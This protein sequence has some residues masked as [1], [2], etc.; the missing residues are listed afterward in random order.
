[1]HHFKSDLIENMDHMRIPG[2]EP[3]S[4]IIVQTMKVVFLKLNHDAQNVPKN[5]SQMGWCNKSTQLQFQTIL[6][7]ENFNAKYHLSTEV[8]NRTWLLVPL[9]TLWSTSS[10]NHQVIQI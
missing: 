6:N 9:G 7:S 4:V 3:S 8:D 10:D 2:T 5:L 1:M